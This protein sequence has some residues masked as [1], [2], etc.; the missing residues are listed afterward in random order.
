MDK[1]LRH[2]ALITEF[3]WR[4]VD[5]SE[6]GRSIYVVDLEGIRLTDFVG[7][8]VTF[9]RKAS[10]FTSKHY[11]ERSGHIFI[12]NVPSWFNFI[13]RTLKP[14]VDA[15]TV[16]KISILRGADAI[17]WA[18]RERIPIENIPP[19]YGGLSM[20]LGYSPEEKM[21]AEL[22]WRGNE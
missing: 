6:D 5:P 15:E 12:V 1:L 4:H 16:D 22:M 9:V 3:M 11:P 10:D 18:L 21:L 19:D 7:D 14:M 20:P 13:W 8:V 2:F 17:H